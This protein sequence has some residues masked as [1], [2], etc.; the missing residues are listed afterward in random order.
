MVA[1]ITSDPAV[2]KFSACSVVPASIEFTYPETNTNGDFEV[3]FT[4]PS[5]SYDFG[6]GF[7]IHDANGFTI[8]DGTAT[9][10]VTYCKSGI[11]EPMDAGGFL[12]GYF[13][14]TMYLI[15]ISGQ[16]GF[17]RP[18]VEDITASVVD[19]DNAVNLITPPF[20]VGFTELTNTIFADGQG[21]QMQITVNATGGVNL[22]D[23]VSNDFDYEFPTPD[24]SATRPVRIIMRGELN[25]DIDYEFG[26]ANRPINQGR[27]QL[28]LHPDARINVLPG[29][30]LTFVEVDVRGCDAMWETINVEPGAELEIIGSTIEDGKQAVSVNTNSV[31]TTQDTR[32]SNNNIGVYAEPAASPRNLNIE[33]AGST[34]NSV[35]DGSSFVFPEDDSRFRLLPPFTGERPAAG[36]WLEDVASRVS[37]VGLGNQP[38]VFERMHSGIS[39]YSATASVTHSRFRDMLRAGPNEGSGIFLSHYP[40]DPQF[41]SFFR[42]YQANPTNDQTQV[43]FENMWAAVRLGSPQ[44]SFMGNLKIEDV[45]FGI[46]AVDNTRFVL[47]DSDITASF[48]GVTKGVGFNNYY[49][50]IFRIENNQIRIKNDFGATQNTAGIYISNNG[51]ADDHSGIVNDNDIII[52]GGKYGIKTFN[53]TEVEFEKNNITWAKQ[54]FG[55]FGISSEGSMGDSY[56]QNTITG[57]TGADFTESTGLE[58]FGSFNNSFTCNQFDDVETGAFFFDENEATTF[59]G[60]KFFNSGVGLQIGI[61]QLANDPSYFGQQSHNGNE[62]FGPFVSNIGAANYASASFVDRSRVITNDDAVLLPSTFVAA[63]LQWFFMNNANGQTFTCPTLSPIVSNTEYSDVVESV[64]EEDYA[65][66]SNWESTKWNGQYKTAWLIENG[67][68]SGGQYSFLNSWKTTSDYQDAIGYIK[69]HERIATPY[70]IDESS[71]TTLDSIESEIQSSQ[72][73]F[74]SFTVL[75]YSAAGLDQ[76]G[77]LNRSSVAAN[78]DQLTTYAGSELQLASQQ[79]ANRRVALGQQISALPV[80]NTG[81]H[82]SKWFAEKELEVVSD[83]KV[84]W[85]DFE[86]EIVALAQECPLD[87]GSAVYQARGLCILY[88]W[89]YNVDQSQN[90]YSEKSNLAESAAVRA[91][92]AL[93]AYPNP[94]EG[95]IT[96]SSPSGIAISS[97][98]VYDELG[99]E[100]LRQVDIRQEQAQVR[101]T[102][103]LPGGVYHIVCFYNNDESE[104]TSVIL[105]K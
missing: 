64:T 62:W 22:S 6:S 85:Y 66:T 76:N 97:I 44:V 53:T 79:I 63:G 57:L 8:S 75:K 43:R 4:F 47:A 87:A 35:P 46:F 94:T 41:L 67:L 16:T 34:F 20:D 24:I 15:P 12:E 69:T 38:N 71:L 39:L 60:N 95:S 14:A 36:V 48:R 52:D 82:Y 21:Q 50:D 74:D 88:D 49:Q 1:R 59:Q 90:C 7:K 18:I 91:G 86:N 10:I 31:F 30:K 98:I 72:I 89:P 102:P 96:V 40:D 32:Y 68:V 83:N 78:L 61:P 77:E 56:F 45:M 103:N 105:N 37:F 51:R 104:T 29:N 81:Q 93:N 99:R 101:L 5:E 23:I 84:S 26:S 70:G 54:E 92:S 73:T 27:N 2:Q 17:N 13:T 58:V 25:I 9:G 55:T 80:L 65:L 42:L 100:V 33:V 19:A 11:Y 28:T 3:C